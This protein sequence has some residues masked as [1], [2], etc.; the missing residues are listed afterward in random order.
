MDT[1]TPTPTPEILLTPVPVSPQA[2]LDTAVQLVPEQWQ[3][4]A[5]FLGIVVFAIGF[6][7]VVEL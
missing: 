6:F 1:P 5:A 3:V 4:L 2:V 7:I